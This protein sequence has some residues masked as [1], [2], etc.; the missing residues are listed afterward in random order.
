MCLADI[1]CN[2]VL[3]RSGHWGRTPDSPD[4]DVY[5]YHVQDGPPFTI[6]CF[7]PNDD[8]SLVTVPQCRDF[9]TG[10]GDGDAETLKTTDG[11]I[12]YDYWCPCYDANGSNSGK[13]IAE[14][15][16]FKSE[17]DNE[18]GDEKEEESETEKGEKKE[19]ESETEKGEKKEEESETEKGEKEDEGEK[20]DKG[21]KGVDDKQPGKGPG[22]G[23][24]VE[25]EGVAPAAAVADA[26]VVLDAAKQAADAAGC[27]DAAQ[28]AGEADATR[29]RREAR[30]EAHAV[31]PCVV[32]VAAVSTAES[33]LTAA[34]N[35]IGSTSAAATAA[36]TLVA[37]IAV[38]GGAV[39]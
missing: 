5:H 23:A 9:Y 25:A 21:V 39:F 34:Q 22:K 6:G 36:A 19:E 8:G 12:E 31:D 16:V 10:C 4:V 7:G 20:G 18:K 37:A 32:L 2:G 24:T 17:T 15:A 1:I 11:E 30:R 27:N 38:I 33:A 14:L 35:V 28:S 3:A 29:Q 26:Q 13:D